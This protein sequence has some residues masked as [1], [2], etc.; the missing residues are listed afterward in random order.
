MQ[1]VLSSVQHEDRYFQAKGFRRLC[2][3]L[4]KNTRAVWQGKKAATRRTAHRFP[5]KFYPA[6]QLPCEGLARTFVLARDS[7]RDAHASLAVHRPKLIN[8]RREALAHHLPAHSPI[9]IGWHARQAQC[10]PTPSLI[11]GIQHT[12]DLFSGDRL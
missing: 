1:V 2:S 11:D 3:P 5:L 10:P 12:H 8:S 6:S 7:A 4:L 9:R